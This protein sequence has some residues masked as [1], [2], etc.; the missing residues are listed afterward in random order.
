MEGID[1]IRK[2]C[3]A[4]PDDPYHHE[5]HLCFVCGYEFDPVPPMVETALCA[6][7]NWYACP[8]CGGC[9]CSLDDHDQQWIDTVRATYCHDIEKM[10]AVRVSDLPDTHNPWA[11]RGLGLQLRFCR[12]WARAT[13]AG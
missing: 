1:C 4:D 5:S 10:A 7:C 9:R 2:D 6:V 3:I 8:Q 13:L 12:R 11:R